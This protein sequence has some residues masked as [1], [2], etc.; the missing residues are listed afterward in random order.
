MTDMENKKKEKEMEDIFVIRKPQDSRYLWSDS[1]VPRF[2]RRRWA[3]RKGCV[4]VN[5][6]Q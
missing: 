2:Q 3:T 6:A 1:R 5:W 4:R